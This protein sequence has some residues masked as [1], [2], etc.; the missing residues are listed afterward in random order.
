MDAAPDEAGDA[1]LMRLAGEGDQRAF[2][3]LVERHQ[4]LV[5]GMVGRMLGAGEGAEDIAQQV[6]VRAWRSAPRY[7]PEA[8]FT[9]WLLT[10]A[11]NLVF[12]EIKR[13]GRV[14]WAAMEYA[15]GTPREIVDAS[16]QDGLGALAE[17]EVQEAI[18]RAIEALPE[19]QRLA[20]ILRRYED[21]SYEEIAA[22]LG[23][24]L[25]SVKSLIF[26]AREELKTV[27]K[28]FLPSGPA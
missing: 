21:L 9:T 12:N 27:L 25:P 18:A 6:F 22:V 28:P 8:K 19:M 11:R 23:T 3:V 2:G 7:R 13:R 5:I 17:R 4:M 14:K 1:E 16:T 10:I 24:T 15:D 20:L 26:R